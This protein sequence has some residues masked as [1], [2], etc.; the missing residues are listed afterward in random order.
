VLG[1]PLAWNT[2]AHAFTNAFEQTLDL[3]LTQS[4]LTTAEIE[5]AAELEQE[6]YNHPSWT[7]R[8]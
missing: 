6:K 5:R 1:Y 7:D 8:V 3:V 2:A 4:E